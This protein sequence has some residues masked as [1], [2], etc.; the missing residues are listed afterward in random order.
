VPA[1]THLGYWR[2]AIRGNV[3]LLGVVSF[4]T[5]VSSEMI[6][7]LLPVFFTGLVSPAFAA[8]YIGVMDGVAESV[9]SLLKLLAGKWSDRLGARK[10]LALAGYG[11]STLARPLMALA[12]AGWH[13]IAL[14]LFDRIGKGIRTSPRDALISDSADENLRGTAFSF[15]R[16]MDHA[17]AVTG[18]LVAALFLFTVLGN[19]L[20]WRQGGASAGP[21]EMLALRW[22]FT[23]ALFP[24]LAAML[25]LWRR[26][27]EIP[28][29]GKQADADSRRDPVEKPGARFAPRY[30]LFLAAVTLFTLGNSSDLFLILF[31]QTRFKL[32]LG[33]VIAMWISLHLFKILFSLPG[34]R[35]SDRL[36][37]R[38][39]IISGWVIYILVYLLL[40]F[41][42]DLRMVWALLLLYGAYYG[43]TEGAE[44]ALVADYVPTRHRGQAYG[45]YH[46]VVG[47]SALPA[48]LM[49]GLFWAAL[50]PKAAFFIG[51]SLAAA[52]TLTLSGLI[53]FRKKDLPNPEY[54]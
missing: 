4:F 10:P 37:R 19:T 36:G 15:H 50:G 53:T 34:G 47:I 35:F 21:Q 48:S 7:P 9:S 40:P 45:W 17:G 27:Q 49:F 20:L 23:L 16:M 5:D 30:Y 44:R 22:L 18:P 24:G 31:A 38:A 29:A 8:I 1:K 43:M 46:A 13:V 28:I 11:I 3:L 25:V 52:A 54:R 32:G 51:A 6:Y 2:K 12:T 42:T 39:A 26:V 33:Y 14:R 41:A